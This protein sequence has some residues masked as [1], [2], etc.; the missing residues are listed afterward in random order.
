MNKWRRQSETHS[1]IKHRI[2]KAITKNSVLSKV[3]TVAWT[4]YFPVPPVIPLPSIILRLTVF[5]LYTAAYGISRPQ[6]QRLYRKTSS[7]KYLRFYRLILWLT[8]FLYHLIWHL[9]LI[10]PVAVLNLRTAADLNGVD[11][12][13]VA[14]ILK[15]KPEYKRILFY[16][17][18]P[19]FLEWILPIWLGNLGISVP[20]SP[21]PHKTFEHLCHFKHFDTKLW[22]FWVLSA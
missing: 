15:N 16:L 1:I 2:L 12:Y 22:H 8:I 17:N 20:F 19:A 7:V 11:F 5:S 14:W 3:V 18:G 21:F 13:C 9:I 10:R 6:N 4:L